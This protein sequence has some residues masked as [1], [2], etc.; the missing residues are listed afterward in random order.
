MKQYADLVNRVLTEG[1]V[2]ID[3]TGVGTKSIFGGRIE[4]DLRERF[5]LV[6][7]KETRWKVAFLEM[8]FFL[9]GDD[10]IHWLNSQGCHLWDA[11]ADKEGNLPKIYGV[12]WLH[13]PVSA[14]NV[15]YSEINQITK[16]IQGL[17]NNRQSRRHLVSAWNVAEIEYMALPPC[18]WAFEC[19]VSNDGHL[20]M[21][22]HQRSWD[23]ALGAPFNI[24]QYALLLTLL[25]RATGYTPRRLSFCYGD[26]H[27]YLNHIEPMK[28]VLTNTIIKDKC[29]LVIDT[30]N[31]D[32]FSY[33]PE[34][35]SVVGYEHHPFVKLPVAV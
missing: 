30:D 35:F 17:H 33:K 23:L 27:V 13:W 2:R 7:I 34:D 22:V 15:E 18:H 12:Q 10:N 20:D 21:Q 28:K 26:A 25:A 4:F 8:L 16:L 19:Y 29:R 24:S 6:T 1:E 32:I 31:T 5:P 9:R 3:R 14:S 11:L